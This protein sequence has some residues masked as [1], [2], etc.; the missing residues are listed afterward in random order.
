MQSDGRAV[1][2]P[3]EI[4]DLFHLPQ[5]GGTGRFWHEA[6]G[7]RGRRDVGVA[8]AVEAAKDGRHAEVR[9]LA[10]L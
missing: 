7:A 9:L 1:Q 3:G 5:T 4:G 2:S 6:D 8:F 10:L